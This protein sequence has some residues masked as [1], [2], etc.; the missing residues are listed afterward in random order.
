MTSRKRRKTKGKEKFISLEISPMARGLMVAVAILLCL[1]FFTSGMGSV[2]LFIN[3]LFYFLLGNANI[4]FPILL[5]FLAINSYLN[6]IETSD[7]SLILSAS[8]LLVVSSLFLDSISSQPGIYVNRFFFGLDPRIIGING[9]YF[10]AFINSFLLRLFGG[11][12]LSILIIIIFCIL[13]VVFFNLDYE[14]IGYVLGDFAR[15]LGKNSK[16]FVKVVGVKSRE[17][18]ANAIEK[19]ENLALDESFEKSRIKINGKSLMDSDEAFEV[20]LKNT[21]SE[22]K[23]V[24]ERLLDFK[25]NNKNL[26]EVKE[27]N[28]NI[29]KEE[30]ASKEAED[31]EKISKVT[32]T[33]KL[34]IQK[35][36]ENKDENKIEYEIPPLSLLK[37]APKKNKI[38]TDEIYENSKIIEETM[39]NF[40]ISAKVEQVNSGPTVTCYELV[41]AANVKLSKIV[42]LADNLAFSLAS[43]DI[44]IEA[45][46]PGKTAVG[47]EVPNKTKSMVSLE[48]VINSKEFRE[49]DS[50]L[51]LVLGKDTDGGVVISSIDDMPHL[52][53]AG[54]T[55]SGKSVCINSIIISLLYKTSPEDLRMILV[56]PK[57]VELGVY[58]A[59]PHL[60]IPVVTNP[61]KAA[62]TLAWAVEEMERRYKAF[63]ENYVKDIKSYNE[64]MAV[65]GEKMCKIVIIIDELA[66]LMMVASNEVEDYIARLAQMA[67]AA[68]MHLIL[69]TQRPSVDVIT[70]TIKANIPSR[71]SFAVSSQIDSRTILDSSGAEKLLGKGDML[72]YPSSYPK[73]RRIQGCFVSQGEV[74]KVIEYFTNKNYEVNVSESVIQE[75]KQVDNI[76]KIDADPLMMEALKLVVYD[77]Q[78]SISYLQRKLSIGYSR[79]ARIVDQ[80][81]EQGFVGPSKGSKPRDILITEEEYL[82][83]LG[84]NFDE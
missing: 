20:N 44:R 1:C 53:V 40:G 69:A 52:L 48:E 2:G 73:P 12:G 41:P 10:G 55:G 76:K 18:R 66:D 21:T 64:K 49:Y 50:D 27:Y 23:E 25:I 33:D 84:E 83:L 15:K 82:Q 22:E 72:F 43:S 47:I 79:A 58:N 77:E 37:K 9:G 42:G 36:I 34:E 65:F 51:P 31:L 30:I 54:A 67:R 62:S 45:P 11:L 78:A 75:I 59:I 13:I 61:K 71:I 70:G 6:S 7:V 26:E 68:G 46:I 38:N 32:S 19:K 14:E 35:E 3:N 80:L 29:A 4:V 63:A 16:S 57:I 28:F 39:A 17:L 8:G 81:E 56:D 60:L 24:G 74:D 5:V